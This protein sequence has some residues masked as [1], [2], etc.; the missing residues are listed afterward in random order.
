[1]IITLFYSIVL[2]DAQSFCEGAQVNLDGFYFTDE[3]SE[4]QRR[5]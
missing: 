2:F 4:T 1:M 5:V 3:K